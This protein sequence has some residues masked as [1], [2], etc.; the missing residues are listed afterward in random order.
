MSRPVRRSLKTSVR[1][2]GPG[3]DLRQQ[4]EF[5]GEVALGVMKSLF[6]PRLMHWKEVFRSL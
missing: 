4:V 5:I 3:Y 1:P 2:R 6:R